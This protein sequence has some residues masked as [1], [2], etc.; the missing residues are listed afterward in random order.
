MVQKIK[1]SQI[2]SVQDRYASTENTL[3]EVVGDGYF[4]S[5]NA[6]FK[7]IRDWSIKGGFRFEKRPAFPYETFPLLALFNI[8][9]S[10]V[11][12]FS[13]NVFWLRLLEEQRPGSF[14]TSDLEGLGPS[15]NFL[16]HESSHCVAHTILNGQKHVMTRHPRSMR[17]EEI[18]K[19]MLAESF[20]NAVEDMALS[21]T[22]RNS[23]EMW[24]WRFNSYRLIRL[25]GLNKLVS[26]LGLQ[27]A[28]KLVI[29]MYFQRHVRRPF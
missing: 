16:I 24:L 9:E 2:L 4:Y 18:L 19:I 15:A 21:L 7:N 17:R 25:K 6:I 26:I 10:K 29:T 22:K 1:L 11:V 3:P 5:T 20:A 28:S 27:Q 23:F 8:L 13:D 12:P 14:T